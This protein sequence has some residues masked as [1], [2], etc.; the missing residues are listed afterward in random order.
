[1]LL[2]RLQGSNVSA[3]GVRGVRLRHDL[4]TH[5]K[6]LLRLGEKA[7][8]TTY[9]LSEAQI[10]LLERHSTDFR[11]RHIETSRP[12]ELLN[13]DT[14]YWGTLKDVGKVYVQ[15]AVGPIAIDSRSGSPAY[16]ESGVASSRTPLLGEPRAT[17]SDPPLSR[18]LA[19]RGL[20]QGSLLGRTG[21]GCRPVPRDALGVT[22]QDD[23]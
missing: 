2:Q 7:Q 23:A 15:V 18:G 5:T 1:M 22:A 11:C 3:S 9:V 21:S 13:Q 6:R 20:D 10:R 14:S 4:E 8:E 12:D 16:R 19:T 17:A